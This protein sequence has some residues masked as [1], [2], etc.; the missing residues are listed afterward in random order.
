M[1]AAQLMERLAKLPPNREVM[2]L[3]GEN[4]GGVPRSITLS[5]TDRIIT[6]TDSDDTSDCE[7]KVGMGVTIIGYGC[8]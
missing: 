2:I 8:Y 1:T 5:P 7:G 3:D 4:G 6:K